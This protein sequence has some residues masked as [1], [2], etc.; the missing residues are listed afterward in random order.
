DALSMTQNISIA[1]GVEIEN[2]RG[3]SESDFLI[4]NALANRLEGM[5]GDDTLTGA[6]GMDVLDGGA[7]VDTAVYAGSY[8]DYAWWSVTETS[9][10]VRDLRAAA[11]EGRDS[12]ANIERLQFADRTVKIAA[13]SNIDRATAAFENVLRHTPVSEADKAF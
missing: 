4:G 11:P 12:L 1:Y 3:G 9:W 6:G 8:R 5:A 7:G 2:A 10:V 13:L